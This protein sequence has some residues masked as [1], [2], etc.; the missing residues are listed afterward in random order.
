[1]TRPITKRQGEVLRYIGWRLLRT[2][3]APTIREIGDEIGVR[4]TNGVN[5]HLKALEKKGQLILQAEGRSRALQL[6]PEGW[7]TMGVAQVTLDLE[8]AAAQVSA[9]AGAGVDLA[10][11]ADALAAT[12]DTDNTTDTEEAA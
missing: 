6:T 12:T 5:D 4:S 7:L 11:L 2:G 10:A 3:M 1:M 8:D 9:L